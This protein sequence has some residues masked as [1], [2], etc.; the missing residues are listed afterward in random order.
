MSKDTARLKQLLRDLFAVKKL[1]ALATHHD[2]QPYQSL[3]AFAATDDLKHLVFVTARDT[4]KFRNILADARVALLVDSCTDRT[5]DFHDEVAVT[6]T[7][8]AIEVDG[9]ERDRLL[10]L[11]LAR[12]PYLE[13]F[14]TSPTCAVLR[15]DVDTYYICERFEHVSE[16]QPDP[17][18]D[19]GT[20]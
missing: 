15:V 16:F 13:E 3:I 7:G 17:G 6:A 20:A 11:H 8:R 4:R 9:P 5:S 1:A 2:G 19:E 12:H 10:A 18:R 14:A